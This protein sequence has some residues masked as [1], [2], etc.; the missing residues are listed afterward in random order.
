MRKRARNWIEQN[1]QDEYWFP[2]RIKDRKKKP[3]RGFEVGTYE[4][5]KAQALW[6]G[7]RLPGSHY[8]RQ[9]MLEFR[10][11]GEANHTLENFLQVNDRVRLGSRCYTVDKDVPVTKDMV[12]IDRAWRANTDKSLVVF[13]L[14]P[15]HK[16]VA[17]ARKGIYSVIHSQIFQMG[18]RSLLSGGE[19]FEKLLKL[20]N[21]LVK[22]R[23]SMEMAKKLTKVV[24]W[25]EYKRK[26]GTYLLKDRQNRQTAADLER[27]EREALLNPEG[28]KNKDDKRAAG[29]MDDKNAVADPVGGGGGGEG[30]GDK[31]ASKMWD[32]QVDEET[33]KVIWINKETGEIRETKPED[34]D[35]E[36]DTV[37]EEAFKEAQKRL[38]KMKKGGR[39]QLGGKKK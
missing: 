4:D 2:E 3:R 17:L 8:I 12:P 13:K 30:E 1:L 19:Y 9:G 34:E 7:V 22:D 24:E 27:L 31:K 28:V 39:K 11:E 15:Q 5:L 36:A 29:Y 14:Q 20:L 32:E 35:E 18:L 21:R 25:V 33:L 10:T 23:L 37:Q 16:Y 26:R 38:A 6:G